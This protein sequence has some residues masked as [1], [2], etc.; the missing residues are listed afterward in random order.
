MAPPS[1]MRPVVDRNVVMR[2]MTIIRVVN[3]WLRD[4][5]RAWFRQDIH[6]LISRRRKAAQ[7]VGDFVDK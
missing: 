7:V 1:Y 6:I 4:Q 5:D 2:R 3:A